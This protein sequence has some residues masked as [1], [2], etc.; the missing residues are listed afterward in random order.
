M[1]VASVAALKLAG[2]LL[3]H[4]LWIE[5]GLEDG[6]LYVPQALC[7]SADG[8]RQLVVFE[9]KTQVES[10]AGGKRFLADESA[11]FAR[12][13]FAREGQVE[14]NAGD[15]DVLTLDIVEG[16]LPPKLTV[17][18]PYRRGGQ[19]E[20]LG[21]E[22]LLTDDG[23]LSPADEREILLSLRSGATEHP[24]AAELWR[25][26]NAARRERPDPFR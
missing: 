11:K 15:V 3:A 21:D 22:L 6:Q 20:L 14:G 10:I 16:A 7:E 4:A 8:S 13:V 2:F 17:I 1:S 24:G 12:C 26:W 18:Q 9:A 19:L 25:E 23:G 5:D